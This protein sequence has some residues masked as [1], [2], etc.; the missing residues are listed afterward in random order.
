MIRVPATFTNS[1]YSQLVSTNPPISTDPSRPTALFSLP[2]ALVNIVGQNVFDLHLKYNPHAVGIVHFPD[3]IRTEHFKDLCNQNANVLLILPTRHLVCPCSTWD[4]N[5]I[6]AGATFALTFRKCEAEKEKK[7]KSHSEISNKVSASPSNDDDYASVASDDYNTES[8]DDKIIPDNDDSKSYAQV[9]DD[10]NSKQLSTSINDANDDHRSNASDA[11]DVN[12]LLESLLGSDGLDIN[13]N[14]SES[15]YVLNPI[16]VDANIVQTRAMLRTKKEQE[17]KLNRQNVSQ[18]FFPIPFGERCVHLQKALRESAECRCAAQCKC[19]GTCACADKCICVQEKS[20]MFRIC[21][22]ISRRYDRISPSVTCTCSVRKSCQ[23][24]S[25]KENNCEL[26]NVQ[27]KQSKYHHARAQ[28]V[29]RDRDDHEGCASVDLLCRGHKDHVLVLT[30]DIKNTRIAIALPVVSKHAKHLI[31]V[32]WRTF[33]LAHY[34]YGIAITRIHCDRESGVFHSQDEFLPIHATFTVSGDHAGNGVAEN[35]N[36]SLGRGASKAVSHLTNGATRKNLWAIA[37]T[38]T[39]FQI[40]IE[41]LQ[42]KDC[43]LKDRRLSDQTVIPFLA[44]GFAKPQLGQKLPRVD[45]DNQ[46]AVYLGPCRLSPLASSVLLVKYDPNDNTSNFCVGEKIISVRGFSPICDED[47]WATF[48]NVHFPGKEQDEMS[49]VCKKC[50][51]TRYMQKEQFDK[52]V[53]KDGNFD[54]ENSNATCGEPQLGLCRVRAGAKK[55]A[56][57]RLGKNKKVTAALAQVCDNERSECDIRP[58][59]NFDVNKSDAEACDINAGSNKIDVENFIQMSDN[60]I[61]FASG[62][63]ADIEHLFDTTSSSIHNM[64]AFKADCLHTFNQKCHGDLHNEHFKELNSP[65]TP[66]Y[67][68]PNKNASFLNKH[69]CEEFVLNI[70]FNE[71]LLMHRFNS[72]RLNDLEDNLVKIYE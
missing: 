3:G 57:H 53:G 6:P 35:F 25:H 55:G 43:Q 72:S 8:I 12:S 63:D 34:F 28:F 23:Q 62:I 36:R 10:S 45:A 17:E 69:T 9:D 46:Y 26:C 64:Q 60:K 59:T 47:K 11:S 52:L 19:T 38:H 4:P 49:A 30:V 65:A 1:L 66:K 21:S 16:D 58:I 50:H 51:L 15:S 48:P 44:L 33:N 40:S 67:P 24:N 31:P 2:S 42:A 54:C 14:N 13:D 29:A 68:M 7:L 39:A 71:R 61:D 20:P 22:N 41:N 5:I 32:L 56:Q 27:V 18:G 70:P 37:V